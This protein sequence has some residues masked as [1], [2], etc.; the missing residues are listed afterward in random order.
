[1]LFKIR[2]HTQYRYS[3]PVLLSPQQL[4]F[5]P[6]DDG[7]QRVIAHHLEIVPEPRGRNAHIDLEGNFVLQ[8]WFEQETDRFDVQLDMEVET[9]RADPFDF[10]LLPDAA[11]LPVRHLHDRR[12]VAG[13]LE[14]IEADDSVTAFAAELSLSV[15]RDTLRFLDALTRQLYSD[16]EHIH[17]ET[18]HPQTPAFTLQQR[19]GACRDLAVLFVDCCRAE[20]LVARFASGYQKGNLQSE[21]RHL[22]AWP[23]VYLPGGG[24][25]GFDPTHGTA[26]GD[27]H[28][29]VAAAA[30]PAA[31]MPVIGSFSGQGATSQLQYD[32]GIEVVDGVSS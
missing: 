12:L 26:V 7:A 3:Q 25:R 27:T 9:L 31:T 30:D 13:Y 32:V 29:T 14:R 24:W 11:A 18:G 17:R 8:A 1:M 6:R 10:V 28:V 5:R 2:H 19:R 23:E 15:E 22:H 4:R 16:F 20:G 21:R